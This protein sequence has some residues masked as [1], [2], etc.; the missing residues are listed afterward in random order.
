MSSKPDYQTVFDSPFPSSTHLKWSVVKKGVRWK[1]P[2]VA[3]ISTD[4]LAALLSRSD[5]APLVLDVRGVDEYEVSHLYGAS[6]ALSVEEALPVLQNM[7]VDRDIVLYCSVGYRSSLL[8][9][10]L[11]DQGFENVYNLE[12]G[13][14]TWANEGR[15]MNRSEKV[16]PFNAR[17]GAL[18]DQKYTTDGC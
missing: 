11:L 12:G 6:R 14:F 13:L 17:W 16:H 1:F 10:Q 15:S 4:S 5:K 7:S 2:R 18:L 3:H 8:A 9:E